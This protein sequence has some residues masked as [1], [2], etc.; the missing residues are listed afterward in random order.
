ME[1]CIAL[2]VGMPQNFNFKVVAEEKHFFP[3]NICQF[4]TLCG[5]TMIKTYLLGNDSQEFD[6][7]CSHI[8]AGPLGTGM[9]ENPEKID[10]ISD[11]SRIPRISSFSEIKY[12]EC[13]VGSLCEWGFPRV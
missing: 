10:Q 8:T 1:S 2:K 6:S 12:Q 11:I 9:E 7:V 5:G 3:H 13:K 4:L